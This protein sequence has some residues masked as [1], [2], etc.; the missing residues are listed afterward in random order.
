MVRSQ[1]PAGYSWFSDLEDAFDEIEANDGDASTYCVTI[2]CTPNPSV[3]ITSGPTLLPSGLLCTWTAS[4][5]GGVSPY[6]YSWSGAASG[7]G[8]SLNAIVNSSDY[9]Y[10]TATDG[11]G[12]TSSTASIYITIDNGAEQPPGCEEE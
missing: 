6:S 7:S 3:S 11:V 4:A 2:Y 9:L 5:S 1:S 8:S 12:H 10:V